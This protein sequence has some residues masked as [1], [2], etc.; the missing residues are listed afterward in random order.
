[1][2]RGEADAAINIK[3]PDRL[4]GKSV[5]C[6]HPSTSSSLAPPPPPPP[7][8]STTGAHPCYSCSGQVHPH[9]PDHDAAKVRCRQRKRQQEE[10]CIGQASKAQVQPGW[11]CEDE[12]VEVKDV[13]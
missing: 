10:L 6:I 7:P 8:S 13:G 3:A 4:G 5:G 12:Q 1:M 2:Q 9:P 11:S